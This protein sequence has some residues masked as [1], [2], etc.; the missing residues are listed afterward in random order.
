MLATASAAV[1]VAFTINPR[2]VLSPMD[3][4]RI[5]S[6]DIT[7][8][9]LVSGCGDPATMTVPALI[10]R[11]RPAASIMTAFSSIL[12]ISTTLFTVTRL[13]ASATRKASR[14]GPLQRPAL[15]PPARPCR[16]RLQ[17]S[18]DCPASL[19]IRARALIL[20]LLRNLD[21]RW[22]AWS[23]CSFNKKYSGGYVAACLQ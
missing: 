10:A 18:F 6:L 20:D 12:T 13:N 1:E 14:D 9:K 22:S 11:F 16:R 21:C 15:P 23:Q 2:P 4:T 17:R 7:S 3:C 5:P 8:A 19:P